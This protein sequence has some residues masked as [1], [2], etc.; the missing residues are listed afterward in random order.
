MRIERPNLVNYLRG[1][2]IYEV[3]NCNSF[4]TGEGD[5]KVG[6]VMSL[7]KSVQER[8]YW[9]IYISCLFCIAASAVI[10]SAVLREVVKSYKGC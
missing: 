2:N 9:V 8:L 1:L 10:N 5:A 6:G 4:L 3:K 7:A